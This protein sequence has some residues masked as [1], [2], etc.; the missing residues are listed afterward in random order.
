MQKKKQDR[1][2]V[3]IVPKTWLNNCN[4]NCE[5]EEHENRIKKQRVQPQ[6]LRVST[7]TSVM[8]KPTLTKELN[9]LR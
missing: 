3:W 6:Q 2:I 9:R 8:P 1:S 7:N 4:K 5:L